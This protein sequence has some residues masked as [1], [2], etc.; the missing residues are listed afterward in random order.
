MSDT[1]N[2]RIHVDIGGFK[3]PLVIPRNDEEIYRRAEEIVTHFLKKYAVEYNQRPYEQ[4]L[5]IVALQLAV[6]LSK[7][8]LLQGPDIETLS[9]EIDELLSERI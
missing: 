4:I 9:H 7:D 2:F 1:E 5:K 3:I 6:I 8:E